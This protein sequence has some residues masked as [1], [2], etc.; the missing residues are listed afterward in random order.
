MPASDRLPYFEYKGQTTAEILAARET[1]SPISLLF[2]FEWGIQA[3][4]KKIGE[5][6]LSEEERLVLAVLAVDRE[7]NNGGFDQ[8]FRNSS[9]RFAPTIVQSLR[10]LGRDDAAKLCERAIEALN[11]A[12]L[13]VTA[14][15]KVMQLS[16]PEREAILNACDEEYFKLDPR[17]E[18]FLQFIVDNAGRIQVEATEDYSR[19]TPRKEL[20]N[21]SKLLNSLRAIHLARYHV[22]KE[23]WEPTL[24]GAIQA[25]RDRAKERDIPATDSE[26]EAAATMFVFD[27][28]V[29]AEDVEAGRIFASR[30]FELMRDDPAFIIVQRDWIKLL[31]QQQRAG[32]ADE[33][34]LAYLD[35]L[36]SMDQLTKRTQN[37]ILFWAALLQAETERLPRSV[38]FFTRTFP[39]LNLN[40]PLPRSVMLKPNPVPF[41]K[42]PEKS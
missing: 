35:Y 37:S 17:D 32:L 18:R 25:A 2:A 38:E 13:T 15:E 26:I 7:V 3:K 41:T 14:V 22:R 8:F 4:A 34:S 29:R 42:A 12:E 21:A 19:L 36:R 27:R 20:S 6:N 5:K 40:E 1:H 30:A 16:D 9:R 31:L 23:K 28:A 11:L 39:A 10:T 24:E 33:T